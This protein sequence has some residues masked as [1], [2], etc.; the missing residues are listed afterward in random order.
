MPDEGTWKRMNKLEGMNWALGFILREV[1]RRQNPPLNREELE[2]AAT[3]GWSTSGLPEPNVRRGIKEGFNAVLPTCPPV[4][5]I[6]AVCPYDGCGA[7]FN[8]EAEPNSE[9]TTICPK[10]N[11]AFI[12][13]S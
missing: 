8:V 11:E 13:V 1:V 9:V 7:R 12:V 6:E 5:T 3:D 2:K 10:C 4:S